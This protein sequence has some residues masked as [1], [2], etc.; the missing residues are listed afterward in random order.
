VE[1]V[2][3]APGVAA[4]AAAD[5]FKARILE[6]IESGRWGNE[7]KRVTLEQWKSAMLL[8]GV[9]RIR[10]GTEAAVP[11]VQEFATALYAHI[12]I[13]QRALTSMPSVTLA[14]NVDRMVSFVTHMSKFTFRGK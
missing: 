2:T 9:P 8:K 13:G 5:K 12:E 7:V 6:A 1:R 14:D 11:E 10:A 3:V 4:A